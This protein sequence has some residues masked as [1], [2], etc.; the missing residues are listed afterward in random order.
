MGEYLLGTSDAELQRLGYQ[1]QAWLGEAVTL[2]NDAGFG[3]GDRLLDLGCGP[4][5]ATVDL[6]HRVGPRGQVTALDASGKYIGHLQAKAAAQGLTHID[7]AVGDVRTLDVEPEAYDGAF[8]R[9]VLCFVDAPERALDGI[10]QA[11]RPGGRVVIQD[12][13][14][15]R[16]ARLFPSQ[17]VFE[18]LFAAYYESVEHRGGSYDLGQQLPGLLAARGFA[19]THLR[20]F[21]HTARPGSRLWRWFRMFTAGFVPTLVD[22]SLFSDAEQRKLT[23]AL[24]AAEQDPGTFF[25]PPPVLGL[26]A[27][28]QG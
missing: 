18:R 4:G 9:W 21:C 14:N 25:F 26:V 27:E 13:F 12:Y 2:W 11:L 17:P 22:Q 1:H 28:K 24:D 23:E 3:L 16:A 20:P 5:F 19:V 8:A 10:A 15:Y 6:A 7:A